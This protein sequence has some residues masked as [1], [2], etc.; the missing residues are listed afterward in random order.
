MLC[1]LIVAFI[2][3]SPGYGSLTRAISS[4]FILQPN[5]VTEERIDGYAGVRRTYA[6]DMSRQPD[7][8][9][10][11]RTLYAYLRHTAVH[12]ELDGHIHVDTNEFHNA[13]ERL[14]PV[15]SAAA[16]KP[17]IGHTPGNYWLTFPIYAEYND[18]IMRITLTPIYPSVRDEQPMFFMIDREPL[19]HMLLLP[20]EGPQLALSLI[21]VI[22]GVFLS[23]L[24]LLIGL[25]AQDRPRVF[26][27]GAVAAAA[28]VWK[29]CGLSIVPLL[30]DYK[31]L[32][33]EIWY[34]GSVSYLLMMALSLQLTNVIQ[35]HGATR[36]GKACS[37]AASGAAVILLCLQAANIV[38]LHEVLIPYGV[39]V[40]L[41]HVP[42]VLGQKSVRSNLLWVV[43]TL[44][45]LGD[46][47][48]YLQSNFTAITASEP[49]PF[50]EEL[51]H[52]RAYLSVEAMLYAENLQISCD[53]DYTDFRLPA[54]TLQPIVE[55]AVKHSS[56]A[57]RDND[58]HPPIRI[59][60]RTR[61]YA[62]YSEI[63]VED[64][65]GGFS[66]DAPDGD[67]PHVGLQNVR[68]RL[69]LMCGGTLDI[70]PIPGGTA[71]VVR[72]PA[73]MRG[74]QQ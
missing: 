64:N 42:A 38:E 47:S 35:P 54:L 41:L 2:H 13:D 61:K 12:L 63:A 27:L 6:F 19:I 57:S 66:V 45:A 43:P 56:R 69:A 68:E 59:A 21:A 46:F 32:S 62:G 40:A 33:K 30:L 31:T 17:Y 4:F 11:S 9:G 70:S 71:V 29:L 26:Y 60:I 10:R 3:C 34:A 51:A 73:K 28:G 15:D 24:S 1:I 50:S 25:N 48:E 20:K 22:V 5:S 18:Q 53:A 16:I 74:K 72:V 8:N 55:N 39:S 58:E 14:Y 44:L 7:N 49:I 36:I 52:T 23:V 37:L 65:S 67:A